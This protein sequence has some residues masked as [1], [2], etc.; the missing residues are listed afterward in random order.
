[1]EV[2]TIDISQCVP[3]STNNDAT[4][5]RCYVRMNETTYGFA[6]DVVNTFK[7]EII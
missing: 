5:I 6:E 3:K 7:C 4:L 2:H 1:M